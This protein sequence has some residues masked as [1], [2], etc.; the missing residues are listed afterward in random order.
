LDRVK[1]A[2]VQNDS[3]DL[4]RSFIG[5]TKLE[6]ATVYKTWLLIAETLFSGGENSELLPLSTRGKV[7]QI[8]QL[9]RRHAILRR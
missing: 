4:R 6:K 7:H 9:R 5:G 3:E 2:V 8:S 1:H